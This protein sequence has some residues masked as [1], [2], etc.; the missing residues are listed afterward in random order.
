MK[1]LQNCYNGGLC[2][3]LWQE[4]RIFLRALMAVYCRARAGF[5]RRD[6]SAITAYLCGSLRY[7]SLLGNLGEAVTE[8]VDDQLEPVG[9]VELVKH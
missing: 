6:F 8:G 9:D 4:S 5:F 3:F 7:A 2:P 1:L